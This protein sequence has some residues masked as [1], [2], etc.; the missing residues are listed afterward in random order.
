LPYARVFERF[1]A[2][3]PPD[4]THAEMQMAGPRLWFEMKR[5]IGR[6]GRRWDMRP[7]SRLAP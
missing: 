2:P 4:V 5:V 3:D 6:G 1:H 7:P